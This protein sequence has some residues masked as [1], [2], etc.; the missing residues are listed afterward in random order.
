MAFFMRRNLLSLRARCNR[1]HKEH[2]QVTDTPVTDTDVTDH[3]DRH[4][5]ELAVDGHIAFAAYRRAGDVLTLTHTIVP[6]QLAGQG[7]G[8][9]L[10]GAVLKQVRARGER[11]VPECS[12]V[13]A[14]LQKHPE[15]ADLVAG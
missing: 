2:A 4:R 8:T 7:I 15:E 11:I 3:P 12:F 1:N 9:K 13:S 14:Y 10:I 5:F 6:Q